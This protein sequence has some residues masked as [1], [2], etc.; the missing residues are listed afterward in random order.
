MD[1]PITEKEANKIRSAFRWLIQKIR[2]GETAVLSSGGAKRF[3]SFLRTR[4]NELEYRLNK[5]LW[6]FGDAQIAV[7]FQYEY[8]DKS[9][10]WFRT[11]GNELWE[12]DAAGLMKRREASINDVAIEAAD[13]K[14]FWPLDQPRPTYHDGIPKLR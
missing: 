6:A 11:Y 1:F 5:A 7:R 10:Q 3:A 9:G 8:H 4:K 14:F 12:F 2:L 13:R